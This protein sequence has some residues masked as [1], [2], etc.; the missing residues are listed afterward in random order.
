MVLTYLHFRI[1]EFPLNES[2]PSV[3]LGYF[4]QLQT[5]TAGRWMQMIPSTTFRAKIK[6]LFLEKD[7]FRSSG[8]KLDLGRILP[9][10]QIL[11]L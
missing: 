10:S 7:P 5:S 9:F 11:P 4:S 6:A 3:L 8:W 2:N 1:L